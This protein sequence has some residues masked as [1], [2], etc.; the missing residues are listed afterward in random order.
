MRRISQFLSLEGH[1][2][3]SF[4]YGPNM[5]QEQRLR[6]KKIESGSRVLKSA[7]VI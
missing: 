7:V 6:K 2:G 4:T 3:E 1:G 5:G